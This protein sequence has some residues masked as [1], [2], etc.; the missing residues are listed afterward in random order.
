MRVFTHK[1]NIAFLFFCATGQPVLCRDSVWKL[2]LL[3]TEGC[4]QEKPPHNDVKW[5][6]TWVVACVQPQAPAHICP[7]LNSVLICVV[8]MLELRLEILFISR[9]L[10][11]FVIKCLR[12]I[13]FSPNLFLAGECKNTWFPFCCSGERLPFHFHLEVIL[14][15]CS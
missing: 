12:W 10:F 15:Q 8:L 5:N 9:N 7:R 4:L 1:T 3:R 11:F 13:K 6:Q 2:L 14:F